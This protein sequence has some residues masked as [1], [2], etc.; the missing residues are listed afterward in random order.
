MLMRAYTIY[1]DKVEAYLKPFFCSTDGEAIRT[2]QD[3]VNDGKS[4]FN[5][6]PADYTLFGIGQFDDQVGVLDNGER[7]NLGCALTFLMEPE[8]NATEIRDV[9]PVQRD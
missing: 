6:H 1:D 2:F 7:K 3:A 8:N 9:S 5:R 4:M